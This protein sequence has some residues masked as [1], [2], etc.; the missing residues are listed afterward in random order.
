MAFPMA[1]ICSFT[2]H[3]ISLGMRVRPLPAGR[4]PSPS[5]LIRSSPLRWW[6][7]PLLVL[8]QFDIS[9]YGSSEAHTKVAPEIDP[10]RNHL[11]SS[12]VSLNSFTGCFSCFLSFTC[13]DFQISRSRGQSWSQFQ[14][15]VLF[16]SAVATL[17]G[18]GKIEPKKPA[19]IKARP[20]PSPIN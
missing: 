9:C 6:K 20:G 1:N 18:R 17:Q 5:R 7:R 3:A 8:I 10:D 2:L 12:A 13:E 19:G 15:L 4:P 14:I 16:S 11:F